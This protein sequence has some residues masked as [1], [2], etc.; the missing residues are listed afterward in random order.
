MWHT[1]FG[2]FNFKL[3]HL[4]LI[5]ALLSTI[6]LITA[7]VI[8]MIAGLKGDKFMFDTWNEKTLVIPDND[9]TFHDSVQDFEEILL[10]TCAYSS[11]PLKYTLYHRRQTW[12]NVSNEYYLGS[13]STKGK[14]FS[15]WF[16]LFFILFISSIFPT[17]RYVS[18]KITNTFFQYNPQ[19]GPDVW[20][21]VEYAL[22]SPLQIVL[23]SCAFNA[24]ENNFLLMLAGLQM[25][26]VLFGYTIETALQEIIYLRMGSKESKSTSTTQATIN[27]MVYLTATYILHFIIW[28]ILFEKFSISST[29]VSDCEYNASKFE[30]PPAVIII[31]V[32]Q[33]ITF[34]LF[35]VVIT[36]QAFR[37]FTKSNSELTEE[38]VAKQWLLVT[39]T[40]SW[41]SVTAKLFLEYGMLSLLS[42]LSLT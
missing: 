23:I 30:P 38:F 36:A 7:F 1:L 25:A 3:C 41:L 16:L 33:F 20:R 40:Y 6:G 11:D 24:R 29:S 12:G 27:F 9:R 42:Q 4:D 13:I 2:N 15:P 22:T 32:S 37:V 17:Y 18:A 8:S 5:S 19:D 21:W 35:G 31:L 26:L 10:E 34:T 28:S 14:D 39:W